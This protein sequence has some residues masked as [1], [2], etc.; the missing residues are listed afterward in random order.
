MKQKRYTVNFYPAR[1]GPESTPQK[2]YQGNSE[3]NMYS[4]VSAVE[5]VLSSTYESGNIEIVEH[6]E[7]RWIDYITGVRKF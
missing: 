5:L 2:L 3:T 6:G 1:K 7:S 4:H